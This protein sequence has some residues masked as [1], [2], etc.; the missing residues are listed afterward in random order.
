MHVVELKMGEYS[1][2]GTVTEHLRKGAVDQHCQ[3]IK[4]DF[5]ST[6]VINLKGYHACK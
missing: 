1:D 2:L 3:E 6:G 5:L 4:S